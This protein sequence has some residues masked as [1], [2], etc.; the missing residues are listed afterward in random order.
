MC[1]WNDLAWTA[2]LTDLI[3]RSFTEGR[4]TIGDNFIHSLRVDRE[5][6]MHM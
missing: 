5:R 3:S 1:E 6:T 2:Q 4:G